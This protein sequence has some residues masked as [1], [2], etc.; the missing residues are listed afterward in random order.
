MRGFPSDPSQITPDWLS[1]TLR[2]DTG[3]AGT[4][5]RAVVSRIGQ[6]QSFMGGRLY[7]FTLDYAANQ[8]GLPGSLIAKFSPPDAVQARTFAWA[9]GQEVAFYQGMT[10][11][12]LPVPECHFAGFDPETGASLIVLQDIPSHNA[13]A[14]EQGL[15]VTEARAVID[16]LARLHATYWD[17]PVLKSL[18][19]AGLVTHLDLAACWDAYPAAV[20]GLLG[21]LSLPPAFR[22][23]GDHIVAHRDRIFADLLETGPATCLHRDVQADNILF[24]DK[25]QAMLFDWQLM[26][27]GAGAVDLA[28]L[29][30]SS[31]THETRRAAECDLIAHYVAALSRQGVR[32]YTI[33]QCWQDY[34]RG[35]AVKFL[36]TVAATVRLDNTGTHKRAWRRADLMRLLAF[37]DQHKMT[38]ASFDRP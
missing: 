10:R 13:V 24:D 19:G 35:V 37:C 36:V 28:Y 8:T 21:G 29:L 1:L 30:I 32:D 20:A 17:S 18:D 23:L 5:T 27:K 15:A 6:D 3:R 38:P 11:P 22:I 14:F 25:G 26:G 12:G 16:A 33:D 7:R 31:L 34:R 9:N 2:D 4:V